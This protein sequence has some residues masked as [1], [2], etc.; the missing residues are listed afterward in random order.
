MI[1]LCILSH[2]FLLIQSGSRNGGVVEAET[3]V[4]PL[5]QASTDRSTAT[6]GRVSA[7]LTLITLSRV[8][9][10][11]APQGCFAQTHAE[12]RVAMFHSM[13]RR[14]LGPYS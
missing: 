4:Q 2:S 6:Y 7:G 10:K 8:L 11:G 12:Q 9:H 3:L 14:W 13:R 5:D 1:I